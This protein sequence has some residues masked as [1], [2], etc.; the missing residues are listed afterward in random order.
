MQDNT[1]RGFIAQQVVWRDIV[2]WLS[3][4]EVRILH[5]AE[6]EGMSGGELLYYARAM[7]RENFWALA[8]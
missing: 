1:R 5:K 6:R 2:T 8:N 3:V 7:A 4:Q